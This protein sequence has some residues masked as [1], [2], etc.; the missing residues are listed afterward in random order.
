MDLGLEG[1]VAII[2]GGGQGIGRVIANTLAKEGTKI[3]I[4]DINTDPADKVVKE[5]SEF[6]GQALAVKTDVTRLEDTE[7]LVQ[8]AIEK[9]GQVDVLIHNAS[10][11]SIMKFMDTPVETWEK[12]I[13]VGQIGAFNCCR[14]LLNHMIERKSGRLIFIGSDAGRVGDAYQP[15]Y[16]S[17]KGG[18]IAFCKSIAQDVGPKG[19]TANVVCPALTMTEENEAFLNQ[20]YG[21]E[22]E[23]RAKKLYSAYPMRRIANSEDIAYAVVFLASDK[24]SYITGQTISVN[25]GYS[26]I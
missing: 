18:V 11:F 20:V 7:K 4:A 13:G 6:G 26:M 12:I 10:I 5:I 23:K 15:V 9:F 2:T 21:L 1:K 17:G 22:D 3:V 14:A 16:A 24:A 8:T 25:G 19:I